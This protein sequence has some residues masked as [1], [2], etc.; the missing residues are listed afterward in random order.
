M[1]QIDLAG[2]ECL[3]VCHIIGVSPRW[4]LLAVRDPGSHQGGMAIEIVPYE[5][6]RR[7]SIR[8]RRA[9]AGSIGFAEARP[10]EIIAA[11]T[12]VRA[13]ML[14]DERGE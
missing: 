5:L 9:E 2:G 3:D 13:A 7:V 12:L 14:P 11:E 1:V 10:P 8:T 6:I 4:V